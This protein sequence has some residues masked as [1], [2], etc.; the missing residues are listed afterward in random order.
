MTTDSL[1][2]GIISTGLGIES[3]GPSRNSPEKIREA[4]SQFEALLISQVLKATHEG[5]G[6]GEGWLGTGEDQTAGSIMGLADDYFAR[7]LAKRGG[8]GLARMVASGLE[9]RVSSEPVNN[10]NPEPS[11]APEKAPR[12]VD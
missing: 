2:P 9:H 4:A 1:I 5:E 12:T 3:P 10:S 6:E 11:P 7:A 8:F